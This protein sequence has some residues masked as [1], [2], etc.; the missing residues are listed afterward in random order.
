M[1]SKLSLTR[2]L[3]F[4][5]PFFFGCRG[6][7]K[8]EPE[9]GSPAGAIALHKGAENYVAVDTAESVVTW[10]GAMAIGGNSHAGYVSVSRGELLIRDGQLIGGA[11][12]VDMNTIADEKYGR[13][14][15][16]ITHLKD[17]DFF[18]VKKFPFATIALTEVRSI[19]AVDKE[20]RGNLTI[21]GIT[22]PVT[23]PAKVEIANGRVEAA[24]RLV[25]DRTAWGIHYGS[26]KFFSLV[27][28]KAI[29]DSILFGITL[30]AKKEAAKNTSPKPLT[31]A[32]K[33]AAMKQ[34]EATPDG[35]AFKEWEASPTGKKVYAAEAKI[36]KHINDSTNMEAVVTSLSLPPGSRLGFGV[37]ARINGEDYILRFDDTPQQLTTL[38]VADRLILRSHAVSH[39]PRYAYP[40]VSGEYVE[41]D[42]KIL[43]Q[44]APR[45]GGC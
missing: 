34:W 29:S 9:K 30:V 43:Y 39:A 31:D 26:G 44:H 41:R 6:P 21:K 22:R 45:K 27:A 4:L 35:M 10:K 11:V 42:G 18:D 23:F 33:R 15:G 36:R 38:K 40:I 32:E 20:I 24:G 5:A 28:D 12:E 1:N 8:A 17:P 3:F 16:L 19:N 2:L 25:I 37:M 14:N 13:D 7:V